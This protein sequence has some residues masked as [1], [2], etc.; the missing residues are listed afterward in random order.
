[1]TVENFNI[2]LEETEGWLD[3]NNE[4]AYLM[5]RYGSYAKMREF[6]T[7][8]V[9]SDYFKSGFVYIE[10][11][12]AS[13]GDLSEVITDTVTIRVVHRHFDDA[14][15]GQ[16]DLLFTA[17]SILTKDITWRW[18]EACWKAGVVNMALKRWL[19]AYGMHGMSDFGGAKIEWRDDQDFPYAVVVDHDSAI[20]GWH[21]NLTLPR[22]LF[23]EP[24]NSGRVAFW[25][26]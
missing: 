23:A 1:M 3:A 22:Y 26:C 10:K 14:G 5:H 20:F 9:E 21:H 7:L 16:N 4:K 25:N 8:I 15:V 6:D 18:V 19:D 12:P 2:A 13:E 24:V 17:P 11:V